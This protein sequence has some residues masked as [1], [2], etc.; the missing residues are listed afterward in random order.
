MHFNLCSMLVFS[1]NLFHLHLK[2]SSTFPQGGSNVLPLSGPARWEG[3]TRLIFANIGLS[4]PFCFLFD[5]IN[6]SV[7]CNYVYE[8]SVAYQGGV[9]S[10]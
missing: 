3:S 6:L 8:R 7:T 2:D 10:C 1:L 5:S 4:F 9:D